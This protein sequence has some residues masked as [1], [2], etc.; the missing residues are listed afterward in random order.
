MFTNGI[1]FKKFLLK[2]LL[3]SGRVKN[4]TKTA[5]TSIKTNVENI[6]NFG[7]QTTLD[8]IPPQAR[9]RK[10]VLSPVKADTKIDNKPIKPENMPALLFLL[11]AIA[12]KTQNRGSETLEI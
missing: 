9:R 11:T 1:V 6:I 4:N 7:F 10:L 8:S 3:K 5:R 2:R 12:I